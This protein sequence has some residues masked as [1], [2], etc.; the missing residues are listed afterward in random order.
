MILFWSSL[1]WMAGLILANAA[2]LAAWQWILL[3]TLSLLGLFLAPCRRFRRLHLILGLLFLG[4]L[5][6]EFSQP[7]LPDHHIA[8]LNDIPEAVVLYGTVCSDPDVRSSSI[9]AELCVERTRMSSESL[10]HPA[11]GTVLVYTGR[12]QQL[13][14]GDRVRAFGYLSTPPEFETFSYRAYLERRQIFSMMG[15]ASIKTL[16]TGGGHA[17]LRN[18]YTLRRTAEQVIAAILPDPEASLLAGILLGI[19]EGIP[20]GVEDAFNRTGATH[21]IAISGFN[22]TIIAGLVIAL[23]GRLL[24]RVR[25]MTAAATVILLYT[26]LVGADAAVVRAAIMGII[27]LSARLLGRQTYAFASLA[28]SVFIMTVINPWLLWDA[29]FQLSFAATLGLILY[30]DPLTEL[31]VRISSRRLGEETAQKAA[32]PVGEYVLMTMAAQMTTLPLSMVLFQRFSLSSFFVNPL[33][34]PVQPAIMMGGGAALLCGL[35]WLPLGRIAA[36][37]IWILLAYTIRI[38]EWC[39]HLPLSSFPTSP[40]IGNVTLVYYALL[41]AVT[42]YLSTPVEERPLWEPFTRLRQRIA[43]PASMILTGLGLAAVIVWR[44]VAATPDGLLHVTVFPVENGDMTFIETPDGRRILVD[45]GCSTVY[46]ADALGRRFPPW[47]RELDMLILAGTRDDQ[48]SGLI[49]ITERVRIRNVLYPAEIRGS[50]SATLLEEF[51]QQGIPTITLVEG[52]Q[53]TR[54]DVQVELLAVSQQGAAVVIEF[55]HFQM[56]LLPG[57]TPDSAVQLTRVPA[58]ASTTA[59]V[60]ADCGRDAPHPDCLLTHLNPM[61]VIIPAD[62]GTAGSLAPSLINALSSSNLLHTEE[63]GWIELVTDGERLWTF[64]ER[65]P[66]SP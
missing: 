10:S 6:L 53:L 55:E 3:A 30:A 24:G 2:P 58:L 51:H 13:A 39:A 63:V 23:F 60:L 66:P 41:A 59:I 20:S 40:H 46:L 5:R 56:V 14:Y 50:V 62:A 7:D 19:E 36:A 61:L 21:I 38:V 16:S 64:T 47:N 4:A 32:G 25:G 18:I 26:I 65:P 29:G 15:N 54:D 1:P 43:I 17:L 9:R 31:F 45:G 52:M 42:L 28:A 12:E 44:S 37:P 49:D 22:I 34:L 8:W 11:T 27:T 57:I 33:I 48:L 35:V